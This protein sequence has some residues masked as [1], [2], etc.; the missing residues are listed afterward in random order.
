MTYLFRNL[1]KVI[2]KP[3]SGVPPQWVVNAV[4][5][6]VTLI[7]EVVEDINRVHGW[8]TLL[9]VAKDKVNPLVEV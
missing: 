5:V 8:H 4:D 3:N 9:L 1:P 6:H 7:E 2:D